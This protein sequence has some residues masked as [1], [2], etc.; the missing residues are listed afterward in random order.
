MTRTL[1]SAQ[2]KEYLRRADEDIHYR[3]RSVR[4][5]MA[6][7]LTFEKTGTQIT[8]YY[9]NRFVCHLFDS[10]STYHKKQMMNAVFNTM[11]YILGEE[12]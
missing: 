12:K 2:H 5:A 6:E 9:K 11:E 8:V 10:D 1:T 4:K 7:K 3:F